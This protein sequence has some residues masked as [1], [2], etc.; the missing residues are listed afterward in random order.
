MDITSYAIG[1]SV[2]KGSGY[3]KPCTDANE[4][5][6][7]GVYDCAD[8]ANTPIKDGLLVVYAKSDTVIVQEYY[9]IAT[10]NYSV[11]CATIRCLRGVDW[12]N[13]EWV[14]PPMIAG[15]EYCTTERMNGKAVYK[16][17]LESGIIQY[18][19]DGETAWKDYNTVYNAAPAYSYGTDDLT[20]GSSELE[21]GK[22]YF[23]YE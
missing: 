22:L 23:V 20:A 4:A 11:V 1:L 8:A 10:D 7:P 14:N 15:E 19:L 9:V 2:G 13:W 6:R 17:R 3:A 21:T 5:I 16:K 18:R 12:S